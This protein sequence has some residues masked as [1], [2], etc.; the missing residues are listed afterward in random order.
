MGIR[1]PQMYRLEDA[2]TPM[3]SYHGEAKVPAYLRRH[4]W[5]AY[6]H[7]RAVKFFDRPWLINLI[8]LGSYKRLRNA[9]LA[10]F[11]AKPLG[12]ILQLACVYGDLTAALAKRAAA[13]SGMLD[14]VDVLP[15]QLKNLK[16]KLPA[17][18]PA[19]LLR[20]DSTELQFPAGRYD[21]VLLFFL[22]H[23]QPEAVRAQTIA[24]AL[25]VL[26]P[27]GKLVIVDYGQPHRFN[28][29]RTLLAP[30]LALFEPFALSLMQQPL[31]ALLPPDMALRR[32]SF[33]GGLYQKVVACRQG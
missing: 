33:C 2:G 6:V 31:E 24:E 28:P 27:G 18:L 3:A 8:L 11:D 16:W 21:G 5:W 17:R 26:K 1:L 29:L 32:Q 25:R 13:Q 22:L 19:R 15:I 30:F 14:V 20:M 10:E 7:P 12:N 23:E 9:A 4:Y